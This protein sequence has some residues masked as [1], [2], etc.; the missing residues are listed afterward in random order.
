MPRR[1]LR[2]VVGSVA[3]DGEG[4]AP[5]AATAPTTNR[6]AEPATIPTRAAV[7]RAPDGVATFSWNATSSAVGA[8]GVAL[9]VRTGAVSFGAFVEFGSVI[10]TSEDRARL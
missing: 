10:V 8:L 6:N 3:A 5:I 4:D 7:E 1:S 9:G 2:S